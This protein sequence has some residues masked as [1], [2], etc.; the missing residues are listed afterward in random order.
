MLVSKNRP[1]NWYTGNIQY[2]HFAQQHHDIT[3]TVDAVTK[4]SLLILA[5]IKKGELTTEMVVTG[6]GT[7]TSRTCKHCPNDL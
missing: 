1:T 3:E 6:T 5:E 2:I 7:E 4:I